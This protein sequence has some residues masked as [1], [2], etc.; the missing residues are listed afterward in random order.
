[1]ASLGEV[2]T[3]AAR[4][5]PSGFEHARNPLTRLQELVS[6]GRVSVCGPGHNLPESGFLACVNEIHRQDDQI[7]PTDALIVASAFCCVDCEQFYTND[8]KVLQSSVLRR[9]SESRGV[10]ILNP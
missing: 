10:K 7:D 4:D 5:V 3:T 9:F 1:M 6:D 8:S 2:M